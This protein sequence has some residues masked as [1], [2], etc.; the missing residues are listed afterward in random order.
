[1]QIQFGR[2]P[3]ARENIRR[4]RVPGE[5]SWCG[6]QNQHGKSWQYYVEHDEGPR[7]DGPIKGQFCNI[8]CLNSYHG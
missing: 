1:M 4:R 6:N 7:H 8:D 2:N 3:F 5:C